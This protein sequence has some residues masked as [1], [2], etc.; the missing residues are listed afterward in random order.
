M[1]ASMPRFE[2]YCNVISNMRCLLPQIKD[3]LEE[4]LTSM[5]QRVKESGNITQ[6]ASGVIQLYLQHYRQY[7]RAVKKVCLNFIQLNWVESNKILMINRI[8][9]G[10]G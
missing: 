4:V 2:E 1:L 9:L 7:Q 5:C 10:W 3:V 8:Q 6:L